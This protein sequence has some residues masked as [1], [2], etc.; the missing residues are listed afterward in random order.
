[1]YGLLGSHL[2]HKPKLLHRAEVPGSAQTAWAGAQ[3]RPPGAPLGLHHQ[4]NPL[5]KSRSS[6][7][8]LS[9]SD[10]GNYRPCKARTRAREHQLRG[11]AHEHAL[12]SSP[13]EE[14]PREQQPLAAGGETGHAF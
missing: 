6:I 11:A 9:P 12:V 3:G 5:H 10:P 13:A 1:M 7:A 8:S 4:Q 2:E 14:L